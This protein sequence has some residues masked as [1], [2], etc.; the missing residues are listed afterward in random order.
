MASGKHIGKVVLKIRDEEKAKVSKPPMKLI[1]AIPRTYMH[2][3]KTY[4]LVGTSK[5]IPNY[6]PNMSC[7]T[8]LIL[9]FTTKVV[10]E[11]LV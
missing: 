6:Y 2:P 4:V 9:L 10:L 8:F 5:I 3:D 11:V 1:N 7:F